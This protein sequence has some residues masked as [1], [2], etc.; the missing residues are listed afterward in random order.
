MSIINKKATPT[1]KEET[2]RQKKRM[3]CHLQFST[4]SSF[5]RRVKMKAKLPIQAA[6]EN[7]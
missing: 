7:K 4:M 2:F 1:R 3:P 6:K 5:S